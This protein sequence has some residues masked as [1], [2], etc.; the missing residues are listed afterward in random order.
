MKQLHGMCLRRHNEAARN[1]ARHHACAAVWARLAA[2]YENVLHVDAVP[3]AFVSPLLFEARAKAS[4]HASLAAAWMA[5][6]MDPPRWWEVLLASWFGIGVE[7]Q[8]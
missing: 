7:K 5:R 1:A 8:P 3:M 2:L 4:E 6:L